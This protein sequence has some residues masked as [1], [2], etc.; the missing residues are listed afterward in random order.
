MRCAGPDLSPAAVEGR[1]EVSN[2]DVCPQQGAGPPLH[3]SHPCPHLGPTGA[4]HLS[5]GHRSRL[6]TSLKLLL[7]NK[8]DPPPGRPLSLIRGPQQQG[9]ACHPSRDLCFMRA[10]P[11]LN[12]TPWSHQQDTKRPAGCWS[13]GDAGNGEHTYPL[14]HENSPKVISV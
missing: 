5:A 14:C 12:S 10:P 7:Q 4:A 2:L 3:D 1:Q 8:A 9:A 6:R 11:P 13:S